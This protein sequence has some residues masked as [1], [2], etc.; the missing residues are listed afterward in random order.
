M[1]LYHTWVNFPIGS[2]T[3]GVYNALE[4]LGESVGHEIGWGRFLGNHLMKDIWHSASA[5]LLK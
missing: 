2:H 4:D 5:H 1:K 3:V